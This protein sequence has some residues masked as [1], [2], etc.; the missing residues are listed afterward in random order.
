MNNYAEKALYKVKI[1][2]KKCNA[3]SKSLGQKYKQLPC[4]LFNKRSSVMKR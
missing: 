2:E 1:E 4:L 3:E